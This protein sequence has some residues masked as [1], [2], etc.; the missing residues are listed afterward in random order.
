MRHMLT[1]S[2]D[3]VF[4]IRDAVDIG[5]RGPDL[6]KQQDPRENDDDDNLLKPII[7]KQSTTADIP[8]FSSTLKH[9][10]DKTDVDTISKLLKLN[11]DPLAKDKD[12]WCALHYAARANN[13]Q[14][15]QILIISERIRTCPGSLE[16]FNC[17]GATALHFAASIGSLRAVRVFLNA[18]ANKDAIDHYKRS[19]LFM[20]SEGGHLKVIELLLSLGARI[21]DNAPARL[22][23]LQCAI[24]WRDRKAKKLKEKGRISDNAPPPGS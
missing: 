2:S 8:Q 9:S 7:V 20:A 11:H 22:K 12:G 18:G 23:E 13:E 15:C 14:V 6:A 5:A 17:T 4:N 21:P 10:I 3:Y 24:N 19:P 16:T 1:R